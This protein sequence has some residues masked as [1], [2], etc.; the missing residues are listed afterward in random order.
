MALVLNFSLSRFFFSLF[1]SPWIAIISFSHQTR[2]SAYRTLAKMEPDANSFPPK[3][4]AGFDVSVHL[5][6][7]V[8]S[9]MQV[10]K[11]MV[12]Q[13]WRRLVY[14]TD[15]QTDSQPIADTGLSS[16]CLEYWFKAQVVFNYFDLFSCFQYFIHSEKALQCI[17]LH[18]RR[19]LLWV[20]IANRLQVNMSFDFDW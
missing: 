3:M 17:F 2:T 16:V 11:S 1:P 19:H 10:C 4:V 14:W 20:R 9:A 13:V 18:E 7:R 5:S 6:I 12:D 8:V 15:R